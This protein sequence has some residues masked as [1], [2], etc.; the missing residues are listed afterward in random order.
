MRNESRRQKTYLAKLIFTLFF[1]LM[2]V[3][4]LGCSN[5]KKNE[6][7]LVRNELISSLYCDQFMI[8]TMCAEDLTGSGEVDLFFFEDDD[9]IFFYRE[10]SLQNAM[11][12]H[13]FHPCMQKMHDD[14]VVVGSKLLSLKKKGALLERMSLQTKLMSFYIRY[15][16][17]I[18]SCQRSNKKIDDT[19]LDSFNDSDEYF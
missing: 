11:S 9:Q 8:Y 17:V 19:R 4:A 16:P 1:A 12:T 6:D 15:L 14:L 7:R 2:I 5:I 10:G 3:F 18:S 13:L